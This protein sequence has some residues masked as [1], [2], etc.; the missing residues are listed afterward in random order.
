M[1][2]HL[3]N[4]KWN[5]IG[6]CEHSPSGC[7]V[8]LKDRVEILRVATKWRERAA[9][10]NRNGSSLKTK[11]R[12]RSGLVRH[13]AKSTCGRYC[14]FSGSLGHGTA[15]CNAKTTLTKKAHLLKDKR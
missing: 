14:Y 11:R 2:A 3:Y 6:T 7:C 8:E 1:L 5:G 4:F 12:V 10:D 9:E 13:D 15:F